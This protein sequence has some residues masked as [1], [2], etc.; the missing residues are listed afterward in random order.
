MTHGE[1]GRWKLVLRRYVP[2]ALSA[3]FLVW[4]VF[5]LRAH[6]SDFSALLHLSPYRIAAIFSVSLL[7]IWSRGIYM[8]YLAVP[9]GA[10][11]RSFEAL[12]ISLFS[13]IGNYA[14]P[15]RG[16]MGLRAV[17]MKTKFA[18]GYRNFA[19]M[20]AAQFSI[21]YL[22]DSILGLIALLVLWQS[23]GFFDKPVF[24]VLVLMF[25]ISTTVQ[26]RS[27]SSRIAGLLPIKWDIGTYL[28][29]GDFVDVKRALI[30]VAGVVSVVRMTLIVLVFRA[31][32]VDLT[33]LQGMIISSFWSLSI[34]VTM[35]PGNLGVT[36]GV[37]IY[38]AH[39]FGISPSYAVMCSL[40]MRSSLIFWSIVLMPFLRKYLKGIDLKVR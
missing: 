3:I 12:F 24:Y 36:E 7:S 13:T 2:I 27:L 9:Y 6:W 40:I 16:G 26:S 4:V 17:Y 38:S 10:R 11:I 18:I 39:L 1:A 22:T 35:T 31:L 29:L 8:K 20:T 37:L 23:Q 28:G 25:A 21:G 32:S 19:K 33:V 14:L 34:A 30:L 15:F 5:Y